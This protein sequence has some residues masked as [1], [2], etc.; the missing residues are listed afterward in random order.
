MGWSGIDI[1]R[2]VRV[3]FECVIIVKE[4]RTKLVL[5]SITENVSIGGVCVILETPLTKDT[6]VELEIHLPDDLPFIECKGRV[7]WSVKRDEYSRRKPAQFDVGI[8]FI[9]I[10]DESKTR[11]KHIIDEMLE[12]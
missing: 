9:E 5:E 7:A 4:G 11:V 12:Y 6:Y 8:E 1:R 2:G 10:S 3:S